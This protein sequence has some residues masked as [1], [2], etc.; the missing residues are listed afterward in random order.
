MYLRHIAV[1][2]KILF[3]AAVQ[4]LSDADKQM[5]AEEM[6]KRRALPLVSPA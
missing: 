1:E 5:I 6:A 2:D 3:P 4:A